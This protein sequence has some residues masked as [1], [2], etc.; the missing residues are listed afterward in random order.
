MKKILVVADDFGLNSKINQGIITAHKNGV[1][2]AVT[3]ITTGQAFEEAITLLKE[4]PDLLTGIHIDLDRFFNIDHS[5]GLATGPAVTPLPVEEIENEIRKQIQALK[6][7]G[8]EVFYLTSHHHT[9]LEPEIISSLIKVAK[10]YNILKMRFFRKY[11]R[12]Q[13]TYEKIKGIILENGIYFPGHFID[14]WYWGNVDEPFEVAELSTH[15]GYGEIWREYEL[16][17]CCD[18]NLKKYLKEKEIVLISFKDL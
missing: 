5:I 4:N 7:H 14:G 10:E 13:E 15:P 12:D 1:V 9:H 3:T 18:P 6:S 17:A 8:I 16:S 11:Y 2:S